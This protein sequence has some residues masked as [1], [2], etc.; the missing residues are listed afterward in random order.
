[1]SDTP[2]RS[3]T[4]SS[5][6]TGSTGS[7]GST[8]ADRLVAIARKEFRDGIRSDALRV[9]FG[10][11]IASTVLIYWAIGRSAEPGVLS[12]VGFL[13]LPFQLLVPVAAIA[14]G[15]VSVAGE[16]AAGSLRL[17][18]GLPPSRTEVV[19]GKFLGAS[20]VLLA[21]LAVALVVAAIAGIVVFGT[22]S[23]GPLVGVVAA[24]ALLGVAFL[25]VAI[26][27]SAAVSS[28]RRAMAAGF[29]GFLG[30]T[31]LWEPVVAGVYYL[32]DGSLPGGE[33]P[34]WL[35]AVDRLNPIEAYAVVANMAGDVGV[36]P[37]R[38]SV[39]LGGGS[40]AAE[41]AG[42]A[43]PLVLAEPISIVV[44]CGWVAIPLAVGTRR[45]R[46]TDLG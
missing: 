9:V 2:P 43:V 25:G 23:L 40:T 42:A 1:M 13:G 32:V 35:L 26:G 14:L 29:G 6:S 37:L 5:E 16:R 20:G 46:R 31:F 24:T 39:G 7:T 45:F 28:T 18:L 34:A 33:P 17:L 27:L 41:G 21:G 3:T 36:T 22:A 11:V 44:L 30:L 15:T 8:T 12:A 38:I 19:V 4:G 10:L